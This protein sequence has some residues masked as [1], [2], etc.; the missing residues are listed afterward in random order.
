[1]IVSHRLKQA[2]RALRREVLAARDATPAQER[3]EHSRWIADRILALPELAAARVVMA[4][5]SFG[6]EVDTASILEGLVARGARLA[7]PRIE[8]TEIVAVTYRPGDAV[9]RVGFGA[10]EPSGGEVVLDTEI[11]VVITPGVA[12]DRRGFRVGYGG[13]YYDRLFRRTRPEAFRVA[14]A[15]ALQLVDEVPHGPADLPV[16]MVVTE[17]E[18][19]PCP[20]A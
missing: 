7:L 10:L 16:D 9:T 1:M 6:S 13:G 11:D 14:A 5:S 8:G 15:F 12:F 20:R 2:K 18:A 3:A 19:I 4:F 17:H